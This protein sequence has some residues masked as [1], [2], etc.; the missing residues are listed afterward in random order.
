MRRTYK[1]DRFDVQTMDLIQLGGPSR[2]PIPT[3][4][5]SRRPWTAE[6]D[7]AL[8]AAVKQWGSDT[9]HGSS[10]AKISNAVG[11]GRTNKVSYALS[12]FRLTLVGNV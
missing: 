8:C 3:T 7:A 2:L 4:S 10:W 6:E 5:T 1:V 11:G 9:G 12:T